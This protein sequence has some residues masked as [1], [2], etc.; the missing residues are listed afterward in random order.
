MFYKWHS[1]NFSLNSPAKDVFLK[2]LETF[3]CVA[4][5]N[6][7]HKNEPTS[8]KQHMLHTNYFKKNLSLQSSMSMLFM[9]TNGVQQ[10]YTVIK[11]FIHA[12]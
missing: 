10:K 5:A 11:L 12:Y 7:R 3:R 8:Q 2:G 1:K 4:K 6:L 9:D